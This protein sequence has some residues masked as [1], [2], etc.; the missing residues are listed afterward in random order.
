M[1][2]RAFKVETGLYVE[3]G[4]TT[5][6]ANTLIMRD[7]RVMGSLKVDGDLLFTLTGTSD[8]VPTVP[9]LNLGSSAVRWD[10]WFN[11]LNVSGVSTFGNTTVMAAGNTTRASMRIPHGAAPTTPVN[12]DLWSS[13]AGL[14]YRL[15]GVSKTVAF[16]DSS[17][18]GSANNTAFLGGQSPA[19]YLALENATGNLGPA[20]LSQNTYNISVSGLANNA[21][22]LGGQPGSYYLN[23][24]NLTGTLPAARLTG[25]YGISISGVANSATY[26]GAND[27]SYY[28]DIAARLGFKPV[29]QGTGV[30]QLA[31]NQVKIGWDGAA[32]RITVDNNDLGTFVLSSQLG[33]GEV[34]AAAFANN[35]A[36]LGGQ[37]PAY[38]LNAANHTGSIGTDR[39]TGSYAISI[40]GNAATATLATTATNATNAT[41]ANSSTVAGTAN[42][43]SFLGGQAPAY[44]L[45]AANLTGTIAAT[46]LTGAYDISITGNAATA[47]T[48]TTASNAS[49]LGGQAGSYYLNSA[50]H[51]GNISDARLPSS[52]AGK[53][54]T[55]S[56]SVSGTVS[57]TTGSFAG[58]L[59]AGGNIS[60][61]VVYFGSG[62]SLSSS[63]STISLG[64][65][66]VNASNAYVN[67]YTVWHANNFNPGN[68][69]A[70]GGTASNSSA[71]S[72]QA[73]SYYLNSSN[74]NAGTLPA[75]R[76]SGTYG[77]N[78]SSVG[79]ADVAY[80]TNATNI[81]A[82]T[83]ADARLPS[84]MAGKTFS[85]GVVIN[86]ALNAGAASFGNVSCGQLTASGDVLA[87]SSSDRRLKTDVVRIENA[88]DKVRAISGYT[89]TRKSTGAR[90]VGVIAQEIQAVLP[91]IVTER[92]DGTLA[93]QYERLAALLIEAVKELADSRAK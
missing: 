66:Q 42:N 91:E 93:L 6:D 78:V 58:D 69:M 47:T 34:A 41:T 49:A 45:A 25:T 86:G 84:T 24:T 64:A 37:L 73:G 50:N 70:V 36:Y 80:L 11:A 31:N 33:D 89:Y 75:A 48:A 74:Q 83:L 77:I 16:T 63:G 1:S 85:S 55:S 23:A 22:N 39:L 4:N 28:T 5:I 21:S 79:G 20:S 15:N 19:Y 17:I 46:R 40:T 59:T 29:Q 57:A 44:Y 67:G 8:F 68:Y 35:A 43:A 3:G 27:A 90:E 61:G 71:L 87:F 12:G 56:I 88:L 14:F 18:T 72:G 62:Q 60:A 92:E 26:L 54:F 65:L 10:G 38:Y 76:L 32:L 9:G 82:G 81:S 2:D 13:T 7:L 51:S 52:M 53:T 30:G